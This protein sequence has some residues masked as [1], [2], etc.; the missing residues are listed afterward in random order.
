MEWLQQIPKVIKPVD[1]EALG[2]SAEQ[3]A[4]ED[5]EAM[6]SSALCRALGDGDG[7]IVIIGEDKPQAVCTTTTQTTT[8]VGDAAAAIA[9]MNNAARDENVEA[10]PI[11][12]T[13]E[14]L[15]KANGIWDNTR[16]ETNDQNN[17]PGVSNEH[18]KENQEQPEKKED[19]PS[20]SK[21]KDAGKKGGKKGGKKSSS[22]SSDE[23][24][25]SITLSGNISDSEQDDDEESSDSTDSSSDD[26]DSAGGDGAA[27]E[28]P[29]AKHP[30]H[31]KDSHKRSTDKGK[32]KKS[33][34][35]GKKSKPK[36]RP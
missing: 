15:A 10:K 7:P 36:S 3:L 20:P 28:L 32:P 29:P 35:D 25:S 26:D 31:H 9:L 14:E 33:A 16:K 34:T 17:T 30:H 19:Q 1:I 6:D 13:N 2:W 21:K 22:S 23:E 4:A 24:T 27:K 11:Y 12:D 5:K 8:N 18:R